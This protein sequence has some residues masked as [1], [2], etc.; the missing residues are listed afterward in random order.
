MHGLFFVSLICGG[1]FLLLFF[2]GGFV[3]FWFIYLFI[4]IITLTKV[5]GCFSPTSFTKRYSFSFS[6]TRESTSIRI[7][8]MMFWVV[9]SYH[10]SYVHIIY[11][12]NQ[13]GFTKNKE[14]YVYD[15]WWVTFVLWDRWTINYL[16]PCGVQDMWWCRSG[17]TKT[18]SLDVGFIHC[19]VPRPA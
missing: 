14:K 18:G 7:C 19:F 9:I 10:M 16:H 5:D 12:S 8:L 15:S 1:H 11:S 13:I 17:I 6:L 3:G 4:G 2:V